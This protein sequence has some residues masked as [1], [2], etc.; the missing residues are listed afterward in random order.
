MS[1]AVQSASP[2][3]LMQGQMCFCFVN[4]V[5]NKKLY[6]FVVT[7]SP[8]LHTGHRLLCNS[9]LA[10]MTMLGEGFV[11]K[12]YMCVSTI[13][14]QGCGSQVHTSLVLG[15]AGNEVGPGKL[16]DSSKKSRRAIHPAAPHGYPPNLG[17]ECQCPDRVLEAQWTRAA[18]IGNEIS[19]DSSSTANSVHFRSFGC[20]LQGS[21]G[22]EA[23]KNG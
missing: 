21:S 9:S 5:E 7:A 3:Q 23:A 19:K 12:S 1:K 16:L 15:K 6:L 18:A 22:E 4:I 14:Q 20:S 10:W 13:I 11:G 2:F 8:Y 17:C